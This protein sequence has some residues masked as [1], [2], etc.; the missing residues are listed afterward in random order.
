MERGLAMVSESQKKAS[1]KYRKQHKK[2]YYY[3]DLKS[4]SRNFIRNHATF[5]DL[6]ELQEMISKQL[7][8]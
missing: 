6:I 2:Q 8:K 3:Y 5:E 1:E 7:K 4:K